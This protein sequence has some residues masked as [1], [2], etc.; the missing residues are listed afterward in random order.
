MTE[1]HI[2]NPEIVNTDFS[3]LYTFVFNSITDIINDMEKITNNSDLITY[4]QEFL[5]TLERLKRL[6]IN[7]EDMYIEGKE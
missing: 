6:Q 7:A 2:G 4:R 3:Q 5:L 1:Y